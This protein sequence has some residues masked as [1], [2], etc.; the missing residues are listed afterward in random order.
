M[1]PRRWA[2]CLSLPAHLV[3]AGC[4]LSYHP[5]K[6]QCLPPPNQSDL[7]VES[8][9][10]TRSVVGACSYLDY[11]R[12]NVDEISSSTGERGGA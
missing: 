2:V 6:N 11:Y 12:F 9:T 3:C 8:V 1:S 7:S 10:P 4:E 5:V